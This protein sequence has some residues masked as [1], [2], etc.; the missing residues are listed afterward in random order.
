MRAAAEGKS[1]S[2]VKFF[3]WILIR[4]FLLPPK[5]KTKLSHSYGHAHNWVTVP[6]FIH[7]VIALKGLR[8]NCRP[9]FNVLNSL[10][11]GLS[12]VELLCIYTGV[13]GSIS[14]G[15]NMSSFCPV[16][17]FMRHTETNPHKLACIVTHSLRTIESALFLPPG[18]P[19]CCSVQPWNTIP[20]PPVL[21][22]SPAI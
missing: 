17:M 3:A 18:W 19:P 5:G 1:L 6:W 8:G 22:Y 15:F 4:I 10:K 16:S 14:Y 11:G 13:P 9:E 20:F 7:L 2:N 21:Y 12:V